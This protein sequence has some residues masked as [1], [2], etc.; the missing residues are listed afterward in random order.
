LSKSGARTTFQQF[1]A[2]DEILALS[3]SVNQNDILVLVSARRGAVSY[4]KALD[5][6][7]E[8]IENHFAAYSR[9][10]IF[11][12]QPHVEYI[13]ERYQE[14]DTAPILR[15]VETINRIGKGVGGFFRKT[16]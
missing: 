3:S 2:W 8:K 13:N 14:L 15:G 4:I 1:E 7:P 5:N 16:E 12:Q 6:L 9:I 11:P 10:I